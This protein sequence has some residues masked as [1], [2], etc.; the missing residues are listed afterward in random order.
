MG[1]QDRSLCTSLGSPLVRV[2]SSAPSEGRSLRAREPP[3]IPC[4][5]VLTAP[6]V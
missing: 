3:L 5:A 1:E 4:G 6:M 2:G